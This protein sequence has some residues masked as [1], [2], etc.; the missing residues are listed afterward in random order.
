MN[1][2]VVL[3]IE[4]LVFCLINS[5]WRYIRLLCM[6]YT[7]AVSPMISYYPLRLFATVG[8]MVDI[9]SIAQTT[10]NNYVSL[11]VS[12]TISANVTE[13]GMSAML[14]R[15]TPRDISP[16][17]IQSVICRLIL[18]IWRQTVSFTPVL[19]LQYTCITRVWNIPSD[20]KSDFRNICF[21]NKTYLLG[22]PVIQCWKNVSIMLLQICWTPLAALN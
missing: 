7:D 13:R 17:S 9:T 8:E 21:S 4:F 19:H 2:I 18:C 22:L 11:I 20:C 6:H 1:W 14:Y 16:K 3:R 15:W 10:G 5:N 12:G